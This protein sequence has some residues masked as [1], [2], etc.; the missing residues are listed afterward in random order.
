MNPSINQPSCSNIYAG[1]S[2]C[3]AKSSNPT[4]CPTD[5][6]SKC[7]QFYEAKI[8]DICSVIINQNPPLSLNQLFEYNPSINNPSCNNL[9]PAC[10]YCVHVPAQPKVP[11]PHQPN[12]RTDCKEYYEAV[13]GDYCY[14]ISL[15]KGVNLND[16]ISWNK[17]VGSTC[18]NMLAGYW[19]CLRV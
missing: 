14:K 12:I 8:G 5:Y 2:Y 19:Y 9:A 7:D 17:D 3:V 1:C 13:P 11:E 16:F 18:S 10:K 4:A 15:E 6:N